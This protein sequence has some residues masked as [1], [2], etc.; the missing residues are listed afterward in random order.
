[1]AFHGVDCKCLLYW[2]AISQLMQRLIIIEVDAGVL[3]S[4]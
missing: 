2:D 1:M 4:V 3:S